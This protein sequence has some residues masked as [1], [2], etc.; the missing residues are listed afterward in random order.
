MNT[1]KV[2][3]LVQTIVAAAP[4]IALL[5]LAFGVAVLSISLLRML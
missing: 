1:E 5:L 2:I 4:Q 3:L